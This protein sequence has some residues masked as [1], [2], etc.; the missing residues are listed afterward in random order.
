M[1]PRRAVL[2]GLLALPVVGFSEAAE[3]RWRVKGTL[4]ILP[5]GGKFASGFGVACARWRRDHPRLHPVGA[6]FF[7]PY[8]E[9]GEPWLVHPSWD[10]LPPAES[11]AVLMAPAEKAFRQPMLIDRAVDLRQHLYWRAENVPVDYSGVTQGELDARWAKW[12]AW[13]KAERA[14]LAYVGVTFDAVG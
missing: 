9:G 14:R 4:I 3:A 2:Q 12:R 6:V 1:L 5:E 11:P 13:R 10:S 7:W 8:A